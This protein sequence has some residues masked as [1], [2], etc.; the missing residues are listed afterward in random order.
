M[1]G[2]GEKVFQQCAGFLRVG[3][4]NLEE[5]YN[6]Y[7]TKNTTKLD[8]TI[9]HPESYAIAQKLLKVLKLEEDDIGQPNFIEVVS[10]R[11]IDKIE[12]SAELNTDED[13]LKLILEALEKPLNHDLRNE[14]NIIPLFKKGLSNIEDLKIGTLLSGKVSNVTHFGC[15]VDIGVKWN[16]M[17]HTSKLKGAKLKI[18]DRVEVEII[19]IELERKRIGLLFSKML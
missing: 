1:R 10:K 2:I 17:I 5:E 8:R 3:P 4:V 9:I 15:F 11:K 16:G 19:D 6:F 13:T 7:K 12:L 18:G 14:L